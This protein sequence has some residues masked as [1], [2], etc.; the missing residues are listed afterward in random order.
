MRGGLQKIVKTGTSQQKY[1]LEV[2]KVKNNCI[3]SIHSLNESAWL[4]LCEE[5]KF[6]GQRLGLKSL[7]FI[8]QLYGLRAGSDFPPPQV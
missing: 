6:C 3:Y 7:A 1:Y 2:L 5:G 4:P 8:C